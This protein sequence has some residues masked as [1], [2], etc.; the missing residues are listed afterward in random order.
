MTPNTNSNRAGQRPSGLINVLFAALDPTPTGSG[1][2][3]LPQLVRGPVEVSLV[4]RH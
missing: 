3:S 4:R 1:A 2:A